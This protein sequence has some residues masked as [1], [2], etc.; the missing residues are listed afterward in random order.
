MKGLLIGS[1]AAVLVAGAV[2]FALSQGDREAD[3]A[4]APEA[5]QDEV[6]ATDAE[7]MDPGTI[8][9]EEGLK[10]ET[11]DTGIQVD[12]DGF[13][14]EPLSFDKPQIKHNGDGT[15]TMKK[16]ARIYENGVMRETPI[17]A[18]ATPDQRRLPVKKR[19]LPA[20]L[21]EVQTGE[22]EPTEDK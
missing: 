6:A 2:A 18:L 14:W 4:E 7:L 10:I 5:V 21:R 1:G 17:T 15:I 16:L 3:T 9:D 19:E 8:V 12:P 11:V 22:E 13:V 20:R